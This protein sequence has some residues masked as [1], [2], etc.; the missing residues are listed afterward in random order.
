MYIRRTSQLALA[1]AHSR[2]RIVPQVSAGQR[3][4][5]NCSS[6][7]DVSPI[8]VGSRAAPPPPRRREPTRDPIGAR[9][10]NRAGSRIPP[11][12]VP[13][14]PPGLE[15]QALAALDDEG[16]QALKTTARLLIPP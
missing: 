4:F 3:P 6:I 12:E 11:A 15:D 2:S 8:R 10:G 1:L 16:D 9:P 7:L 13:E 14:Q 5:P